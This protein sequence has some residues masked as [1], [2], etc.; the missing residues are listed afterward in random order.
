MTLREVLIAHFETVRPN[1]SIY[2]L[3]IALEVELYVANAQPEAQLDKQIAMLTSHQ[4][5]LD[6]AGEDKDLRLCMVEELNAIRVAA[7]S[8]LHEFNNQTMKE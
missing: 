3:S 1:L 4:V 2:G 5:A 6:L 8:A 7:L